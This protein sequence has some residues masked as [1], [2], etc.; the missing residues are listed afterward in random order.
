M[1]TKY[2]GEA[3]RN[4]KPEIILISLVTLAFVYAFP[5]ALVHWLGTGSPWTPY[6]HLYGLG[7]VV[8]LIGL[9]VITASRSCRFGRGRDTFWFKILLGGFVF[10]A[11]LHAAW[12]LAALHLPFKG[13][14]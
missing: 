8:F 6:F 3:V 11:A 10:F 4:R 2:P 9:R 7:A 14:L 12:I 13:G 1:D 5:R